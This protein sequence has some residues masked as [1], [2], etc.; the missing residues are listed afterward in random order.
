[1]PT[2]ADIIARYLADAG[3]KQAFGIP[4]GEI[5]AVIDAL[6]DHDIEFTLVKHENAGGFMAEGTHH[7]SGAPGVLIATLGPGVANAVNVI[8][9]AHQDRV[10]MLFI[11]GCIDDK[12]A[13]TYTHQIFDHQAL[14]APITKATL[15]IADGA[16]ED[17]IDKAL[18]IAMDEPM[19]PV[20]IDVP[21]SVA[22]A[23]QPERK[24]VK[25]CKPAY[26]MP[27]SQDT[28]E[29]ASAIGAA[30]RPLAIAGVGVLQQHAENQVAAF[31]KAQQIP[32]ITSYKG[33]GILPEDHPLSL[34]A[35]GLSPKSESIL[36]PLVK[37]ADFIL[38]LG[39][40]PIEMRPGWRNVW[41]DETRVVELSTLANTHYMHHADIHL[42]CDLKASLPAL[43][44]TSSV[45]PRWTGGE[46][47]ATQHANAS[48]FTGPENWGPHAISNIARQTL[49]EDTI[50]T[51]DTGA[52]RI[53]LSQLWL[54]YKPRSL[55]QST[56]LC[57]MGVAVPM[58]LGYKSV[59]P[60][61]PVVAF[62]GDAGMEMVLG[63]LATVRDSGLAII[64]VIFVDESLALIELKQRGM[65]L[66]N[67]GVDFKSTDFVS[68][69][70]A[71]GFHAEWV[72]DADHYKTELEAALQRDTTTVL[73]CRFPQ[74]AYDGA[75]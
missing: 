72:D 17:I 24:P 70:K 15:K 31:L 20:H 53:L 71:Y 23:M 37:Q 2:T 68:I 12:E 8:A 19:G 54:C 25:R 67:I 11:T 50:A 51:V 56:G 75:F 3:V 49:P 14:L 62:T 45:R 35:T 66:P 57:T 34:G 44:D 64:I 33:K 9:N 73:A 4:G 46:I 27:S 26:G 32:L 21:I 28:L 59:R 61:Q 43:T 7:A 18:S 30:Q 5:L 41:A 39:Y 58:A 42:Y 40:D 69:S 10:P 65:Q 16:V 55:F 1:M 60:D 63:D 52:H 74:K 6:S 22:T 38:L 48:A 29:L 13:A 47:E 36:L